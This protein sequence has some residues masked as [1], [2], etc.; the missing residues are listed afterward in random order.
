MSLR[1]YVTGQKAFGAAVAELVVELGHEL[2][3]ACSPAFAEPYV[4]LHAGWGVEG[5]RHDRLRAAAERLYVPWV[6]SCDLTPDDVPS[7]T[8]IAAHSHAFV[9]RR[10][11]AQA[12]LAIGY[13]P[14]LLP[15]HR[16]RDA[17]RWALYLGERVLGGSVYHL[18]D[19]VDAGPLASQDYVLLPAGIEPADAWREHLFPLGLRLLA[20]V[21]AD[22]ERGFVAFD[23]Q[24]ER[25]ATWEPSWERPP[26]HRPELPELPPADGAA[27]LDFLG[28][29]DAE[30]RRHGQG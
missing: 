21:L 25:L 11:R 22:A 23:P 20:G 27:G 8:I 17:I 6:E 1:V 10:T 12:R 26:L 14:S 5:A 13:H 9:G 28:R 19:R 3:G 7:G 16:G 29:A 30:R 2:V 18:T 24:D 4:H 15:L